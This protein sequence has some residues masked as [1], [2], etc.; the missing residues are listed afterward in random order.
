MTMKLV[1]VASRKLPWLMNYVMTVE[2]AEAIST[3]R[4]LIFIVHNSTS[5]LLTG[6]CV[7]GLDCEALK[8]SYMHDILGV[9]YKLT[10][11]VHKTT[12]LSP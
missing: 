1:M 12:R 9:D 6:R 2:G 11:V 10:A 4:G 5:L 8:G 3:R 7:E